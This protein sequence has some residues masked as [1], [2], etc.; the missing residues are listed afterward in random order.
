MCFYTNVE[1]FPLLC[2]C[3]EERKC[4]K[5]TKHRAVWAAKDGC[6]LSIRSCVCKVYV[7]M[8]R[9]WTKELPVEVS[10]CILKDVCFF[11]NVEKKKNLK[12]H[13]RKTCPQSLVTKRCVGK[14][15]QTS[16]K[17]GGMKQNTSWYINYTVL[18]YRAA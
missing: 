11:T 13:R 5:C 17:C 12:V 14:E 8:L 3:T 10:T 1:E 9:T 4:Q 15:G 7:N 16:L 2:K 6:S 18:Y